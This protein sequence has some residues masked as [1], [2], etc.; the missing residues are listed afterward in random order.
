MRHKFT[1]RLGYLAVGFGLIIGCTPSTDSAT[2]LKVPPHAVAPTTPRQP[3]EKTVPADSAVPNAT[4]KSPANRKAPGKI[5]SDYSISAPGIGV[6]LSRDEADGEVNVTYVAENSHAAN[7]GVQLGDVIVEIDEVPLEGMKLQGIHTKLN[8]DPGEQRKIQLAESREIN[9]EIAEFTLKNLGVVRPYNEAAFAKPD[10]AGLDQK[11]VPVAELIID[12]KYRAAKRILETLATS[13]STNGSFYLVRA[14]LSAAEHGLLKQNAQDASQGSKSLD[15]RISEDIDLA[16]ELDAQLANTAGELAHWLSARVIVEAAKQGTALTWVEADD[17]FRWS[18][19]TKYW[20]RSHG[21][22]LTLFRKCPNDNTRARYL[23]AFVFAKDRYH[24]SGDL[25]S[26]CFLQDVIAY[27]YSTADPSNQSSQQHLNRGVSQLALRYLIDT[28]RSKPEYAQ[29]AASVFNSR[30]SDHSQA[31]L[32]SELPELTEFLELLQK[33]EPSAAAFACRYH[34]RHRPPLFNRLQAPMDA[35][36]YHMESF[37]SE[38]WDEFAKT[39]PPS[40]VTDTQSIKDVI[41]VLS[42]NL[43]LQQLAGTQMVMCGLVPEFSVEAASREPLIVHNQHD[44]A[45]HVIT[46]NLDQVQM[47]RHATMFVPMSAQTRFPTVDQFMQQLGLE[48]DSSA[49][50]QAAIQSGRQ[51]ELVIGLVTQDAQGEYRVFN[52]APLMYLK[53]QTANKNNQ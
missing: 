6:Y 53:E 13:E 41:Q 38:D 8:S 30:C 42:E 17:Y 19:K 49:E 34:T 32:Q 25:A 18:W 43:L 37:L 44:V 10:L 35:Y 39:T 50:W 40:A 2:A 52:S 16:I 33:T 23:D 46:L 51:S 22:W 20:Y 24:A 27:Q 14:I 26:A 11:V 47:E 36:L 28:V 15:D 48:R 12:K 7:A 9:V 31:M 5:L 4:A 1:A 29:F 45:L 3:T 21:G